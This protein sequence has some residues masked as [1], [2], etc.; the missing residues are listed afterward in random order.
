MQSGFDELNGRRRRDAHEIPTDS[1][2]LTVQ[3]DDSDQKSVKRLAV[4]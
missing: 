1:T 4:T 3:K 2:L